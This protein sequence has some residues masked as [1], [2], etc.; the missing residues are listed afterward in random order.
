MDVKRFGIGVLLRRALIAVRLMVCLILAIIPLLIVRM[1]RPVL[2]IRFGQLISHRIGPYVAE[3]E[4]YLSELDRGMHQGKFMD[5]FYHESFICNYQVK[6]M[7]DRTLRVSQAAASVAMLNR[8]I[9]GGKIHQIPWRDYQ[10]RDNY[11]TY[12]Y[13]DTHLKFT[14]SEEYTGKLGMELIGLPTDAPFVCFHARDSTYGESFGPGVDIGRVDYRNSDINTYLPAMEA[15]TEKG[16]YAIRMGALVDGPL[17]VSN[18]MIIDYATLGRTELLD[19]Y[20]SSKCRFFVGSAVGITN[21][22]AAFRRPVVHTNFVPIGVLVAWHPEDICIPKLFYLPDQ[23][24]YMP[25]NEIIQSGASMYARSW[26]YKDHGIE[27]VDSTSEEILDVVLEMEE[28]LTG[29]WEFNEADIE[30]QKRFWSYFDQ[31]MVNLSPQALIGAKYLRDNQWL[32]E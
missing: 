30:L 3:P 10:Q 5:I 16:Y 20:L 26:Q 22:P 4:V 27:L 14:E 31:S 7:W 17:T 25:I 21:L 11:G 19:L 29:K 12:A 18:P 28:R 32:L 23:K 8:L 6:K 24:R 13:S 1:L 15:L 9:P 2:V